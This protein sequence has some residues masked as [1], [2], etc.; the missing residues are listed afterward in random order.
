MNKEELLET[1]EDLLNQVNENLSKI[2]RR[3]NI[4]EEAVQR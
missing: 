4:D 3:L 1:L 2:D